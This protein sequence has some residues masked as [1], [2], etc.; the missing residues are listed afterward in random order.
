MQ[1]LSKNPRGV[2]LCV[3]SRTGH[4]NRGGYFFHLLPD[5]EL[6]GCTLFDF[7]KTAVIRLD[8]DQA[9]ALINHCSGL[10]FSEESFEL[11]QTVI[12]FRLDP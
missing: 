9:T 3:R 7:E 10:S 4:E 11:C 8:L 2:S 5:K 6:T 1:L 12:N